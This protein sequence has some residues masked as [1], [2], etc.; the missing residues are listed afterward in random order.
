AG[1]SGDM[2]IHGGT[3]AVNATLGGV[4]TVEN[5]GTL[6]G[7]GTVGTTTVA[8]GGIIAPGNSVGTLAVAGDLTLNAGSI[9]DYELGSPG[10]AADPAS[11]ASDRIDV[12]G[13]LTLDGTVN[14]AQS[15]D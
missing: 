11:G 13:N 2:I 6:A 8:D 12:T 14:L 5:G 4:V 1:F 7:T 9:L 3:L 10:S 15:A